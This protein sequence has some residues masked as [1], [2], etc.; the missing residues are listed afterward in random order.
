MVER[1]KRRTKDYHF[2]IGKIGKKFMLNFEGEPPVSLR[3]ALIVGI[4]GI[5]AVTLVITGRYDLKMMLDLLY[6]LL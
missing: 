3:P 5:I 1:R 6:Q 4:I 2:E